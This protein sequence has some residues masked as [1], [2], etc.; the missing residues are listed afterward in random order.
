MR[1]FLLLF[2]LCWSAS[3]IRAQAPCRGDAQLLIE[4][5]EGPAPWTSLELNNDPC[6]FQFA[7]VTDRTGGHRPG[8]FERAVNKLNLLQPEFVLSVGD[9][10]EGYTEDTI[11]LIRQW[12]EFDGFVQKLDM[13]FFYVPGNHDITNP[14]MEGLWHRRL[15]PTYYHFVYKDVL[16]LCLNSEEKIQGAGRGAMAD[17]QYD[18]IERTLAEHPDVKWTL[19]FMHQPLWVQEAD[20]GR[21]WDVEKLLEGRK[22]SVFVGHRHHY[23]KY[24]RNNGKYFM[25]ATTGGGSALRGPQMGE[26]DHVVWVTMTAEGPII[27]NLQLEGI[28]DEDVVTE[29]ADAYLREL[30]GTRPVRPEPAFATGEAFPG[31]TAVRIRLTNDRDVPMHVRL[32]NRFSWDYTSSLEADTTLIPPNSVRFVELALQPR[33]QNIPLNSGGV[34]L[35]ADVSYRGEGLPE[36]GY[37]FSYTVGPVKPYL[38]EK[39]RRRIKIDGKLKEWK[40]LPYTLSAEDPSD[41]SARFQLLRDDDFIYLA[42]EVRDDDL[43]SDTATVSWQQDYIAFVINADP[44]AISALNTGSGWYQES[45]V[46]NISPAN[47]PMPASSFYENRYPENY[48]EWVCRAVPGGYVLEAAVP[49]DYIIERQGP[50]WTSLRFNLS[51][52]DKDAAEADRPRYYWQPNWRSAQNLVGSGTFFR[53]ALPD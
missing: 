42:A 26:F 17:A 9:L 52:Q 5:P 30:A 32:A 45:L 31:Q 38:L 37:P 15:G 3:W 12:E 28:W 13:P 46:Y 27:A 48:V 23:V 10:I 41:C 24:E 7:V 39:T 11:E 20:P 44:P 8:V 14:V 34:E 1:G 6:Q 51:L 21:W 43:Q 40:E 22:H 18:Y 4:A 19:L 16:F 2:F 53:D 36:V 50:A 25:L 35:K 49:T 47:G 33:R 29:E